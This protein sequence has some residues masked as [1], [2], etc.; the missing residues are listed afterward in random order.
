MPAFPTELTKAVPVPSLALLNDQTPESVK[1]R[2]EAIARLAMNL[3]SNATTEE[4]SELRCTKVL[5]DFKGLREKPLSDSSKEL[6]QHAKD[7]VGAA[8]TASQVLVAE[9]Q[10]TQSALAVLK[11]KVGELTVPELKSAAENLGRLRHCL[12]GATWLEIHIRALKLVLSEMRGYYLG[13][14]AAEANQGSVFS[15][16]EK[17]ADVQDQIDKIPIPTGWDLRGKKRKAYENTRAP[18]EEVKARLKAIR[19]PGNEIDFAYDETLT[20]DVHALTESLP[21]AIRTVEEEIQGSLRQA[22]NQRQLNLNSSWSGGSLAQLT[23]TGNGHLRLACGFVLARYE[24]NELA[25]LFKQHETIFGPVSPQQSVLV[26]DLEDKRRVIGITLNQPDWDRIRAAA[27]EAE[28]F[29][30]VGLSALDAELGAIMRTALTASDVSDVAHI[31]LAR[32][33]TRCGTIEDASQVI[34]SLYGAS[35]KPE[36]LLFHLLSDFAQRLIKQAPPGSPVTEESLV[37]FLAGPL[38]RT[39]ATPVADEKVILQTHEKLERLAAENLN[40]GDARLQALALLAL[41]RV[42]GNLSNLSI[43]QLKRLYG[44]ENHGLQTSLDHLARTRSRD[45]KFIRLHLEQRNPK[46]RELVQDER[47]WHDA[48][49][50]LNTFL[51]CPTRDNSAAYAS[52]LATEDSIRLGR[53]F[54]LTPDQMINVSRIS[55]ALAQRGVAIEALPA[56]ASRPK[57]ASGWVEAG[58]SKTLSQDL[59]TVLDKGRLNVTDNPHNLS[60]IPNLL[61]LAERLRVAL[62]ELPDPDYKIP[63]LSDLSPTVDEDQLWLRINPAR[64]FYEQ[65]NASADLALG[66]A[67]L[68]P[69][70]TKFPKPVAEEIIRRLRAQQLIPESETV[71]AITFGDQLKAILLQVSN[72]RLLGS[73]IMSDEFLAKVARGTLKGKSVA[74]NIRSFSSYLSFSPTQQV[75]EATRVLTLLSMEKGAAKKLASLGYPPEFLWS[76][77]TPAIAVTLRD[78]GAKDLG[79]STD[80]HWVAQLERLYAPAIVSA[81]D[82]AGLAERV[83]IFR[84]TPSQFAARLMRLVLANFGE[85]DTKLTTFEEALH[86]GL[87]LERR[88]SAIDIEKNIAGKQER[89]YGRD[90]SSTAARSLSELH[91]YFF[92]RARNL[93]I[94]RDG[95]KSLDISGYTPNRLIELLNS[96]VA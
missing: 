32:M 41:G 48:V 31:R 80:S 44:I 76:V 67:K 21:T 17:L 6:L 4:R 16:L 64:V 1:S 10:E 73:M 61:R 89:G 38:T 54:A 71:H 37:G 88:G 42:P 33:L 60:L 51:L 45:Q 18:L 8:R 36:Q 9:T 35:L 30:E 3:G 11:R 81:W 96:K 86:L 53:L 74:E 55:A 27:V 93:L 26:V 25:K 82:K 59:V 5:A 56:F 14:I 94:Q 12:K 91:N 77:V 49:R 68:M 43:E 79:T 66:L 23:A 47:T 85:F 29:D 87:A 78:G 39:L 2:V 57:V 83:N 34:L 46:G 24:Q 15:V 69:D 62:A 50:A 63:D 72:N 65:H 58:K 19:K 7:L 95:M 22:V 52:E 84:E 92:A 75:P 28:L 70:A 40:V 20:A 13:N 90:A